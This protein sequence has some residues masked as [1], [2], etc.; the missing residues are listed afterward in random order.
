MRQIAESCVTD[1]NAARVRIES[2]HMTLLFLGERKQSEIDRARAAARALSQAD[3]ELRLKRCEF[4]AREGIVWLRGES[5]VALSGLVQGLR[6]GLQRVDV[7]FD[8]KPLLPHVTLARKVSRAAEADC[9]LN[10]PAQAF[11]LLRSTPYRGGSRYVAIEHWPLN[12]KT[13]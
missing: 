2:L 8:P 4:R 13:V 7:A 6:A 12:L 1:P 3:F 9:D 11:T 10:W 5:N